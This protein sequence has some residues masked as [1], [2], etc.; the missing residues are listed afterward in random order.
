MFM[1]SKIENILC[2]AC[3][4]SHLSRLSQQDVSETK[5][6]CL[7]KKIFLPREKNIFSSE[8]LFFDHGV[9]KRF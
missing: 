9:F 2:H 5:N 1:F 4:V 6:F 3:H 7:G 8:N